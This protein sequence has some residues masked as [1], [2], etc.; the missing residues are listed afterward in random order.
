MSL[1]V[2]PFTGDLPLAE[3]RDEPLRCRLVSDAQAQVAEPGCGVCGQLE[4]VALVVTPRAKIDGRARPPALVQADDRSEER[5]AFI[6]TRREQLDMADVCDVAE[7]W[8]SHG[9]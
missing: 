9:R 4:R 7:A 3:M 6:E 1:V 8:E 2:D 5:Q